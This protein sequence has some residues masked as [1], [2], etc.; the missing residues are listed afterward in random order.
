MREQQTTS[1]EHQA[2]CKLS[3][4]SRPNN[5]SVSVLLCTLIRIIFSKTDRPLCKCFCEEERE[6]VNVWTTVL[7]HSQ[8]VPVGRR[9]QCRCLFWFTVSCLVC[10]QY[11][12][13]S[14]HSWH[15]MLTPNLSAASCKTKENPPGN[16]YSHWMYEQNNGGSTAMYVRSL[17]HWAP[18]PWL[19]SA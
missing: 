14:I 4:F 9:T 3:T 15:K 13:A 1:Q 19:Q 16:S 11:V 18:Y 12:R 17:W 2:A 6:S 8:T 5:N 7:T 10:E